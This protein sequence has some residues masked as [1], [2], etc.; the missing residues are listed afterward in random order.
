M[1][2]TEVERRPLIGSQRHGTFPPLAGGARRAPTCGLRR[3]SAVPPSTTNLRHPRRGAGH[4][5][6]TL[7]SS[8]G[9][10]CL[11]AKALR[12]KTTPLTGGSAAQP[13]VPGG[14]AW[15]VQDNAAHCPAVGSRKVEPEEGTGGFPPR[16]VQG[17]QPRRLRARSH[18]TRAFTRR[19]AFPLPASV[20]AVGRAV[21]SCS[22]TLS[23]RERG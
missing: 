13:V 7:H 12:H 8:H 14:R 9:S 16:G 5:T 6:P 4:P 17:R 11:P 19:L 15:P 3:L 20:A 2:Q 22:L 21:A 1:Q 10:I 18:A 23:G